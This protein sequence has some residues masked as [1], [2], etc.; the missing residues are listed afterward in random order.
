MALRARSAPSASGGD[1]A[2]DVD[3]QAGQRR[4]DAVANEPLDAGRVVALPHRVDGRTTSAGQPGTA[5]AGRRT[6]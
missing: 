4:V 6:V 5:L 3:E 1:V 2:R